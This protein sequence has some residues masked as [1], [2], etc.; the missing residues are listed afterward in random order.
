M[1]ICLLRDVIVF[2]YHVVIVVSYFSGDSISLY[3][4]DSMSVYV[5]PNTWYIKWSS[6]DVVDIKEFLKRSALL[7]DVSLTSEERKSIEYIK[8][9]KKLNKKLVAIIDEVRVFIETI[10]ECSYTINLDHGINGLLRR[11]S[12]NFDAKYNKTTH[13]LL[14]SFVWK[15]WYVTKKTW[16]NAKKESQNKVVYHRCIAL[17]EYYREQL[18]A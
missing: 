7:D 8:L 14:K 9:Q 4:F 17:K 11:V 1:R 18:I 13:S 15:Y 2:L 12:V 5:Q 16:R 6:S 10:P 3:V